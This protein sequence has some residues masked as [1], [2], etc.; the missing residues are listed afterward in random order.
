MF[1][2]S[3]TLWF[4]GQAGVYGRVRPASAEVEVFDAPGGPGPYGIT[5][6]PAG[7]VYYASLAGS[8]VGRIDTTTGVTTQLDPPT[9]DQGTRRVWSDSAGRV[10]SSQWNAGQVAVYDPASDAWSEWRLPGED[11]QAYAVYVDRHDDVWLS[12]FGANAL[13]RFVPETEHFTV[14]PLPSDPGDVRQIHGRR[15]ELDARRIESIVARV[16]ADGTKQV[17]SA[18]Y[19]LE[20]GKGMS[21]TPEI[22]GDLTTWHDHQNLCWEGNRLGGRLVDGV[23]QPGGELRPTPPMLHVWMVPHPCGP[24]AGIEGH[25]AGCG[26]TH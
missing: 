5:A 26:H 1:N 16:N 11:P 13:V 24:F 18:M 8:Y 6:T 3:G 10:W 22:A 7:D 2:A 25:G 15:N 23:C 14:F 20:F 21:D 9:A 19:I 12:D 17:V 4:T